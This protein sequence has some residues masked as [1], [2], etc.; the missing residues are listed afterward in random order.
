NTSSSTSSFVHN[1]D[2]NIRTIN[3]KQ[4]TKMG[5]FLYKF[6]N[7]DQK[8]LESLLAHGF[9]SAENS[10]LNTVINYLLNKIQFLCL[11]T[12]SWSNIHKDS[13]INFMITTPKPLFYKSVHTKEDQHTVQNIAEEIDKV[14]QEL[15]ID[16][17]V[18]FIT[19]NTPNMKAAWHWPKNVLETS[20][21]IINYFRNYN[22]PLAAFCHLQI[23]K[24]EHIISLVQTVDTQESIEI[25]PNI[26]IHLMNDLFWQNL[27]H[28]RNFLEPFVKFIH[29][30]E[31]DVPLLFVGFLKLCQLKTTIYNN[32]YVPTTVITE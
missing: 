9:Y 19:D 25:S 15:G 31:G 24:Y 21:K 14:M 3:Y 13:I 6:T 16:K 26:K 7:A 18:A 12:D 22:I 4:Q 29:E 23:E 8:E 11:V 30:L 1:D 20:K 2:N 32:D 5:N 28:L 17:F 27:K 10:D